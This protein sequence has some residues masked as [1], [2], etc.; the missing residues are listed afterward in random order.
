MLAPAVDQTSYL[1]EVDRW[2][3]RRLRL[4]SRSWGDLLRSL[5]GVDPITVFESVR[6][7]KLSSRIRSADNTR[8]SYLLDRPQERFSATYFELPTPHPLDYSWWFD[9]PSIALLT[10]RTEKVARRRIVLL[11]TPTLALSL[12]QRLGGKRVVLIDK[13]PLTLKQCSSAGMET[14][15]ADLNGDDLPSVVGD[16]VVAD[17]PWYEEDT[18]GFLCAARSFLEPGGV[19][20]LTCPPLGTRPG[21]KEEWKRVAARAS[22][23]GFKLLAQE[24]CSVAYLS[25]LFEQNAF[26]AAGI[27]ST[28]SSW[29]RGGLALFRCISE[30]RS[31]ERLAKAQ[32]PC[33]QDVSIGDVR[34]RVKIKDGAEPADPVLRTVVGGD[35][36]PSISRRDPHR[37]RV[38]VWTSGNR[39]FCCVGTSVLIH[40]VE[41]FALGAEVGSAVER[42]VCQVLTESER[43]NVS[44]AAHQIREIVRAEQSEVE[45]WRMRHVGVE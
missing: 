41:A 37:D 12:A 44:V 13:D 31:F 39:V 14:I 8:S 26:S 23:L 7:Q 24:E 43:E 22:M 6:R 5:P 21:I 34:I 17:P 32:M 1:R 16:V 20:L 28:P 10:L 42:A 2:V 4:H 40:V 3:D 35:V 19:L 25:P 38:D 18:V 29:R 9:S 11:G 45:S 30:S 36:L 27:P 15:L 33:W